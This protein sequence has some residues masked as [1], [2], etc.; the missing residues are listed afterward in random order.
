MAIDT[1]NSSSKENMIINTL[2][3]STKFKFCTNGGNKAR[4]VSKEI[5]NDFQFAF[6]DSIWDSVMMRNAEVVLTVT[7]ILSNLKLG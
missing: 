1:F 7:V 6:H 3:S 2:L 4:N 5:E